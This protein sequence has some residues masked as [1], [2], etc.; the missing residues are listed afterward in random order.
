[1]SIDEILAAIRSGN[2]SGISKEDWQ[3]VAESLYTNTRKLESGKTEGK[4]ADELQ[5]EL[6]T[7]TTALQN[8]PEG[9]T[10]MKDILE[11]KRSDRFV[12]KYQPFFNAILS[13]V[14]LA[15]SLSQVRRANNA[16]R[17]LV[18]PEAPAIPGIDPSINQAISSAQQGTYDTARAVAPAQQGVLDQY[19]RDVNVAGQIGGGQGAT[20]GALAQ[21]AA[22]RRDSALKGLIPL[23]DQ[24]RA[25]EQGRLDN[26]IGLRSNLTQQNFQNQIRQ[27]GMNLDQYNQDAAAVGQLGAVGRSNVR[28]SIG[29]L[30]NQ[31][32]SVLGRLYNPSFDKY[33]EYINK[34]LNTPNRAAAYQYKYNPQDNFFEFF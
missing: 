29:G 21:T 33:D 4:T 17:Q 2:V 18:R 31:M 32:P 6:S 28:Q 12:R 25:R 15:T 24:V 14:D 34:S 10:A 23:A 9:K 19:L 1:M 7:L 11:Q 22:L 26:L 13:G 16:S 5:A 3:K 30:V 27:Y 20:Y 8:S